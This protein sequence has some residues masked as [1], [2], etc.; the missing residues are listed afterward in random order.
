MVWSLE[1]VRVSVHHVSG[2]AEVQICLPVWGH[3]WGKGVSGESRM[4]STLQNVCLE[5][6]QPISHSK[7]PLLILVREVTSNP[8]K[9]KKPHAC[10]LHSMT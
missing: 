9:W 2:N 3:D 1:K 4:D 10:T 5:F 8:L 7:L 6:L